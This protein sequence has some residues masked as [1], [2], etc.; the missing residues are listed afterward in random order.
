MGEVETI[1][2]VGGGIAGLMLARALHQQGLSVELVERNTTWR[3][4]GGGI[5][6]HANGWRALRAVGLDDA[7]EHAGT[8]VRRW[9]FCAESGEVLSDTDLE[10]LWGEVGP[11]IGIER[12]RLQQV[13]V[14][15]AEGVSCRLGT[16]ISSLAWQCGRAAVTFS[17][18]ATGTYDL[19]VG[20]DGISSTVRAFALG[21]TDL[22]YT[23]AMAWR[24]V[25]PIRPR[26]L[27]TLQFLLGDGCFFGLCP[28][29]DGRTYGFGNVTEPRA[30]E[31]VAGRLDR[32]RRRFAHFGGIVQEYLQALTCDEQIHCAP[33]EWLSLKIWHR[34]RVVLI[35]D[36]AHA[37]SPMMGQ[38]GCMAMEDACVLAECLCVER[39]LSQALDR[40]GERRRPRIG[41]VQQESA[42]AAQS[43][44]LSPAVRNAVL[45]DRGDEMLRR[46]F[47]PLIAPP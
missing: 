32:L 33:V 17:N 38:G 23:G 8:R 21:A 10:A 27:D 2:I 26:G 46:R 29:G 30:R 47:M 44:R 9:R 42:A 6:V 31:P 45:R 34:G 25:A 4:E 36:A 20:A 1:L 18:G 35:G 14:G 24:S 28:T 11:C 15:G 5:M 16:S 39:T 7:V 22:A 13:L 12:M 19:V 41:W 40:Y 37:S 43:F 3:A